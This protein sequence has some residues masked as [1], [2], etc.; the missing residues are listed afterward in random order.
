MGP[1]FRQDDERRESCTIHFITRQFTTPRDPGDVRFGL[2]I[3]GPIFYGDLIR[4]ACG[5]LDNSMISK[6]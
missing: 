2:P 6:A 4:F 3:V 1:G 5:E